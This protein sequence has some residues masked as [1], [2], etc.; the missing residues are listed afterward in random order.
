MARIKYNEKENVYL[1]LKDYQRKLLFFTITNSILFIDNVKLVNDVETYGRKHNK[2]YRDVRY[3]EFTLYAYNHSG[4]WVGACTDDYVKQLSELYDLSVII[5]NARLA[6]RNMKT[7]LEAM[8]N[9][10]EQLTT[11]D[12]VKPTPE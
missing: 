9:K 2:K 3:I 5:P 8:E 12:F 11:P 1:T 7:A 4:E 10:L 6:F